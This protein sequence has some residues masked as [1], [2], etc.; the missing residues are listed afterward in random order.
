WLWDNYQ[1]H[2]ERMVEGWDIGSHACMLERRI[3]HLETAVGKAITDLKQ[4]R[5]WLKDKRFAEIRRG[6]EVAMAAPLR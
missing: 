2:G 1:I 3:R 6:L 5:S 4:T